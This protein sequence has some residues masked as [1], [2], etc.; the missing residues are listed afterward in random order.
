MIARKA[1]VTTILAAIEAGDPDAAQ[2]LL[3]LIYDELRRLARA[4]LA[5]EPPGQTIQA[6]E[7][8]HE[9]YLRLVGDNDQTLW[10][11]RAHFFGAAARAMRRILID[12]ARMRRAAKRGRDQERINYH[13]DLAVAPDRDE[14]L[15]LLDTALERLESQDPVKAR[16]VE[17]RFFAGLTNQ[18]AAEQLDIST[19]TA[20]RHWAYARAWLKREMS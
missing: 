5:A 15:L 3:P 10:K 4:R 17:L 7:L 8:V 12:R 14:K 13:S 18:E 6:T 9:A 16:L 2:V 19:A 11:S 1:D 20:T